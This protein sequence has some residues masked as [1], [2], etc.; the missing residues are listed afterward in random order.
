MRSPGN[1][2]GA[3][4]PATFWPPGRRPASRSETDPDKRNAYLPIDA[5]VGH[6]RAVRLG[7]RP[8]LECR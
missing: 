7:C 3:D 4:A 5:Y 1:I 6:P 8:F 2:Q